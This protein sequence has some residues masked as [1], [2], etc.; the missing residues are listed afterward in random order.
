M[1]LLRRLHRLDAVPRRP[2][3]DARRAASDDCGE[4]GA[5]SASEPDDDRAAA[6][7]RAGHRAGRARLRPRRLAELE[8]ARRLLL[9]PGARAR[10]PADD[11]AATS[12]CC[13]SAT[14]TGCARLKAEAGRML[15]VRDPSHRPR[16]A[17]ASSAA[18]SRR[19]TSRA[20]RRA[21]TASAPFG[22]RRSSA[23]TSPPGL[24]VVT[25]QLP[26]AYDLGGDWLWRLPGD[27]PVERDLRRRARRADDRASSAEM[28]GSGVRACRAIC[29]SSMSNCSASVS[30]RSSADV[31]ERGNL[32]FDDDAVREP[33]QRRE[34]S[35]G[36][37]RRACGSRARPA[38]T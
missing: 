19:W 6:R 33:P 17:R 25:G 15:G 5:A 34:R 36:S 18:T 7:Q 38:G 21:S 26:F 10:S 28:C 12:M 3:D 31:L 29:R 27:A 8:R 37:R 16:A 35:D 4:L 22:T 2:R 20:C 23:S 30:Q 1:P 9:W 32:E 11:R 14:A 13:S 24:P